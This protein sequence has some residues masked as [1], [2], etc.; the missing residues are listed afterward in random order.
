MTPQEHAQFT[1][2]EAEA[3]I[4]RY[5]RAWVWGI[6]ALVILVCGAATGWL[7]GRMLAA[8]P[9]VGPDAGVVN[10]AVLL[11]R[12]QAANQQLRERIAQL[13]QALAGDVCDPA[14]LKA[15]ASDGGNR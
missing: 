5:Q 11:A 14:A 1:L 13:K 6:V 9:P 8:Y 10:R 15:R 12:Q 7:L 2:Y 3:A 4:P